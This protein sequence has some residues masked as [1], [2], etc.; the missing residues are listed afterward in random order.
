MTALRPLAVA[1]GVTLLAPLTASAQQVLLAPPRPVHDAAPAGSAG[2]FVGVNEFTDPSGKVG[3]LR[4]AVND[5][6][7]LAHLF[8]LELRLI[9]AENCTLAL[10]G[11]PEGDAATTRLAA[12][13]AAGAKVAPANAVPIFDA[14]AEISGK[15][16]EPS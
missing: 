14:L 10:S 13:R 2:L 9:P 1:F 15:G 8:A 5:A 16:R 11:E 4:F 3:D 6:V 12:L 7:E